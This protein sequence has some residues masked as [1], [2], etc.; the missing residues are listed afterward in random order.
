MS[1]YVSDL[2][3]DCMFPINKYYL[4]PL[5]SILIVHWILLSDYCIGPVV[6]CIHIDCQHLSVFTTTLSLFDMWVEGCVWLLVLL[7]TGC[8]SVHESILGCVDTGIWSLTAVLSFVCCCISVLDRTWVSLVEI[9]TSDSDLT[10]ILLIVLSILLLVDGVFDWLDA[11]T[12][13]SLDC[14]WLEWSI[15]W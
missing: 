14:I 1:R 5:N 11:L 8:I 9:D 4:N 15:D 3:N 12:S 13:G 2:I 7:L 6:N 10:L